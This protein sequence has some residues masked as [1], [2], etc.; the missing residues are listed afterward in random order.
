LVSILLFPA[1]FTAGM[2]LVDTTDGVLM[3]RAYGWA[4]VHPT[5]NLY[6]NI[7]ITLA[8]AA[9]AFLVGGIEALGLLGDHFGFTGGFWDAV[10]SLNSHVG[11][12][13]YA[14]I[15]LFASCWLVSVAVYRLRRLDA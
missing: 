12:L 9:A 13:G 6:Y 4:F 11:V 14:M 1:L 15:A 8:S 5:R 2:T 7:V 3:M 10:T